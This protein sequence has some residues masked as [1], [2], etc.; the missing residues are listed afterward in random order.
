MYKSWGETILDNLITV[1]V[2]GLFL[3]AG[4]KKK[5]KMGRQA[6]TRDCPKLQKN[7]FIL[8]F[9]SCIKQL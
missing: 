8:S 4:T 7:F 2:L 5:K 3:K 1:Y 9:N 6:L